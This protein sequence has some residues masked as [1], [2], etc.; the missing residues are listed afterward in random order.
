LRLLPAQHAPTL[1]AMSQAVIRLLVATLIGACTLARAAGDVTPAGVWPAS[2]DRRLSGIRRRDDVL[3][4]NSDA[5][6]GARLWLT[7]G[8]ASPAFVYA[9]VGATN[10]AMRWQGLAGIHG[11]RGIDLVGGWRRVTYHFAPG[12]GFDSLDFDGAF[13]GAMV[14]L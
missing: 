10:S 2:E 4:L 8:S 14:S 1:N 11:A 5:I 3:L 6:V 12:A 13:L 9:D 7:P